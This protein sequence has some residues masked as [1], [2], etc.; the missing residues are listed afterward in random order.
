M[1]RRTETR[2]LLGGDP[3]LWEAHFES[4]CLQGASQGGRM[5]GALFTFPTLY[6]FTWKTRKSPLVV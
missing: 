6:S 3:I 2:A 1:N 4:A 5:Q